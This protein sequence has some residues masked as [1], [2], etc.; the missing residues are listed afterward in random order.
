MLDPA[1]EGSPLS[2][3]RTGSR[4]RRSAVVGPGHGEG[5]V[6]ERHPVNVI[7]PWSCSTSSRC[8]VI[9]L[10]GDGGFVVPV[11]RLS[12]IGLGCVADGAVGPEHTGR[13]ADQH[14]DRQG[15]AGALGPRRFAQV[16]GGEARR[17]EG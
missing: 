6:D 13:R 4:F 3:S 5:V 9:G 16:H 17:A 14:V 10:L 8:P 11:V 1:G 15:Q 12:V 2:R 7:S